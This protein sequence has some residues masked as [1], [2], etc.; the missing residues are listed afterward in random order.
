MSSPRG[1]WYRQK[2][3]KSQSDGHEPSPLLGNE[4]MNQ[5]LRLGWKSLREGDGDLA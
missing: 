3:R 1:K 5:E 4:N 2:G